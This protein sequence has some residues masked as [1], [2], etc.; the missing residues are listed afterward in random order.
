MDEILVGEK[1]ISLPFRIDPSGNVTGTSSYSKIWADRVLVA[2]ATPRGTRIMRPTF[3]SAIYES[4]FET[5][6]ASIEQIKKEINSIFATD[7]T[8]LIL[9]EVT[10]EVDEVSNIVYVTVSY[11]LPNLESGK[12]LVNNLPTVN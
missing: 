3:G 5:V 12:V 4:E 6:S 10:S 1:T 9:D 7:L 11:I 8:E 2:L